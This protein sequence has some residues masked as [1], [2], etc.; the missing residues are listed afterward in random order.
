MA[1]QTGSEA[2]I[3]LN[4]FGLGARPDEPVPARPREWL[5]GQFSRYVAQ[6]PA[7]GEAPD[8]VSALRAYADLARAARADS[9]ADKVRAD[10]RRREDG[11]DRYRADV[12]MRVRSALETDT[13]FAER[14]VHF[15]SNHFAISI[16]SPVLAPLAGAFER[17][18][19]RPNVFGSFE[20]M[21]LA[22]ERHP[23]M[24]FFLDQTRSIGPDSPAA[25]RLGERGDRKP[26]INEN[27]AREI[28]ELHTLGVRT[29]YT[30]SDVT[31]FALALSGWSVGRF[32]NPREPGGRFMFRDLVHEPGT[33]T[34]L[35]RHYAQSG[36]DQPLAVLHDLATSQA[37]ARHIATKLVRHFVADE[38]PP[39]AVDRLAS[40]FLYGNGDLPT[41]YR[42]LIDTTAAWS[43]PVAKFKTPW[44]W[45]ISSMRALG[46]R[47]P[48]KLPVAQW[49]MQLGQP[50]WRPGSPAGWPDTSA[51]WAAPDALVRRVEVVQRLVARAPEADPRALAQQVLPGAVS[52]ETLTELGNAE[53]RR[54]GL[55]LLLVSADF[56][57]R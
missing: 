15:W 37:T 46:L 50:V 32:E 11:R 22:V 29:G 36:E 49:L 40:A 54:T 3:A 35:G 28:I 2:A 10:Q 30:Q 19:I 6:A 57:R 5:S 52:R 39:A 18:A 20:S 42:A 26:G 7:F 45:A 41:V 21:L 8:S 27:L 12:E 14:L 47:D 53:S 44:D 56:Q 13:P 38:P 33:R 24:Q 51:E 9:E 23:A 16:N 25:R 43:E 17:E 4:R 31:E 55:A 1:L 48:S 34:V